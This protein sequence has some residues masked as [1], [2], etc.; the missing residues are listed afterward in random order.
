MRPLNITVVGATGAVGSLFLKLL[1]DSTLPLASVNVCASKSSV[2]KTVQFRGKP[3]KIQL[4][5]ELAFRD[6]DIAFISVDASVSKEIAPLAIAQGA[7]VLDDSSAFR[8]NSEVPLVVPEVNAEDL[9]GIHKIIAIPN[10]VTVPLVMALHPLHK[11]NP[12]K[13]VIVDTYQ[14]VSGSGKKAMDGLI[15]ET[16][17]VLEDRLIEPLVYPHRIGFNVIPQVE[18]FL[19]NGY[20]H[21]EN[22][23]IH[24]TKK[25][26]HSPEIYISATCVRV[27][28]M[29]GHCESVHVQF[30]NPITPDRARELLESFQG[31]RVV[32]DLELLQY[33]TAVMASGSDDVL[34]GRIRQD[35]SVEN[36]LVLWLAIDNLRKGAATN[37]LQ[38][39]DYLVDKNLIGKERT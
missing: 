21:E 12:I 26:M 10:C 5:D 34:V 35:I 13:R 39:I 25:I 6:S 3:L 32:D 2:G 37:A 4:A 7:I 24:E 22:K 30:S 33:P 36:G 9:N 29:I 31:V 27:P 28:V 17:A 14:S 19:D 38:I 8:M 23:I 16:A 18:N 20:S 15:A 11:E 1:G